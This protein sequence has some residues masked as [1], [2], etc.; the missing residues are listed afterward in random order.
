ME[1]YVDRST[2]VAVSNDIFKQADAT[3]FG[4]DGKDVVI[5]VSGDLVE[6]HL[7]HLAYHKPGEALIWTPNQDTLILPESVDNELIEKEIVDINT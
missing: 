1:R 7:D 5:E 4:Q 6:L 2:T 3:S